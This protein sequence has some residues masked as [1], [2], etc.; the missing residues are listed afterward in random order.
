M[1]EAD[2]SEV[3]KGDIVGL[4]MY[5]SVHNIG[6][7]EA[8]S[9]GIIK[10]HT[11]LGQNKMAFSQDYGREKVGF[12]PDKL[13]GSYANGM[14]IGSVVELPQRLENELRALDFS[15]QGKSALQCKILLTKKDDIVRETLDIMR[16]AALKPQLE[17]PG[18]RL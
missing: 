12:S 8:V 14:S 4:A 18:M 7:I 16:T 11:L 10:L 5:N 9:G 17:I 3:K 2:L 15:L 1:F 6:F 13:N